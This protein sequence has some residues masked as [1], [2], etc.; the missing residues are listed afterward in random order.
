MGDNR[1]LAVIFDLGKVIVQFDHHRISA[2]LARY[3][4]YSEPEIFHRL[5][6]SGIVQ[7]FDRGGVSPEAFYNAL[8]RE[9]RLTANIAQ[10]MHIWNTIFSP[11]PGIVPLIEELAQ[12]HVLVCLSNTNVWHFTYCREH[13]PVLRNFHAFVLS[14]EQGICKPD[15]RIYNRAVAAASTQPH[16]CIYIDDIPEFVAAGEQIGL[17]GIRFVSTSQLVRA[18]QERGVIAPRAAALS[19]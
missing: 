13:F 12:T 19:S 9:L 14:Y 1:V 6:S 17:H 2:G 4:P 11:T 8:H 5:F 7:E 3:S 15:L 16:Q 10:V 18:L